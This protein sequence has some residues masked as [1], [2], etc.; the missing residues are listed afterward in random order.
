MQSQPMQLNAITIVKISVIGADK[1]PVEEV[2]KQALILSNND[3][4]AIEVAHKGKVFI[5]SAESIVSNIAKEVEGFKKEEPQ[6]LN[7]PMMPEGQELGAK[8]M[9]PQIAEGSIGKKK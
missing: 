4:V 9:S 8:K 1:A 7:K 5:V 3:N 6:Q 2:V